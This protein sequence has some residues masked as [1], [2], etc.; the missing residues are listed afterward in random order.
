[1][2]FLKKKLSLVSMKKIV[3]KKSLWQNFLQ[4]E[5]ILTQIA[6]AVICENCCILE[7]WPGYWTLTKKLITKKP[8]K[9]HLVELDRDMIESLESQ[10]K[11]QEIDVE[12]V[13]FRMFHQDILTFTPAWENYKVI[14]NIPYYITSPI[15]F[16]FLYGVEN[17][18]EEMLILMQKEVG[19][20]I[21]WWKKEK[22]S[23]LSLGM[24]KKSIVRQ[25]I[26]VPREAFYPQPKVDSVVIHFKIHDVYKDISDE[27]FLNFLKLIFKN[28]RKTLKNNLLSWGILKV[29]IEKVF[30]EFR[31][32]PSLRSEDISLEVIM[33]MMYFL[34]TKN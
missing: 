22:G 6:D 29:S 16:H 10:I 33:E 19:E 17:P 12:G 15:L 14:A 3:P 8:S 2:I 30:T 21:L 34:S 20:K 27:K 1:M 31:F 9:L 7:V 4:D 25:I 5:K 26:S 18:P 11:S 32:E 24:K 28:P 13:D 23:V